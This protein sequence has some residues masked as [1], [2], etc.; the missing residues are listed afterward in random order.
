MQTNWSSPQGLRPVS[1]S[2]PSN[3]RDQ[4]NHKPPGENGSDHRWKSCLHLWI[5]TRPPVKNPFEGPTGRNEI[6]RGNAPGFPP[7]EARPEGA[8]LPNP[9]RNPGSPQPSAFPLR[10]RSSQERPP[11]FYGAQLE[12]RVRGRRAGF[13]CKQI[14]APRRGCDPSHIRLPTTHLPRQNPFEGPTGRKEI[15]RG[16]TPGFPQTNPALKGRT[17]KILPDAPVP[18]NHQAFPL[19]LRSSQERPPPFTEPSSKA[20][21]AAG[22]LGFDANK[23]ERP[24]GVATRLIFAPLQSTRPT[25]SRRLVQR[26]GAC[27]HRFKASEPGRLGM[28][29]PRA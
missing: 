16:N 6:A 15:A 20:A 1:Y 9:P 26:T 24:E 22:G 18:S 4:K 2:P 28:A 13:R 10:L 3:P 21:S 14:G 17:F 8:H 27:Q 11:P 25:I 7:N 12:G 19:R 23:L 29:A 5:K